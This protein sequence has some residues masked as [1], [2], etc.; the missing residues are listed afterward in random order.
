LVSSFSP[1]LPLDSRRIA[2]LHGSAT[3]GPHIQTGVV[4]IF[5][6]RNTMEPITFTFTTP[7]P[8]V[9]SLL[10]RSWNAPLSPLRPSDPF[11]TPFARPSPPRL[12]PSH[13]SARSAYLPPSPSFIPPSSPSLFS[14]HLSDQFGRQIDGV[15]HNALQSWNEL[16]GAVADAG[17]DRDWRVLWGKM[18]GVMEPYV[19]RMAH[20]LGSALNI[21]LRQEQTRRVR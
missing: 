8:R 16:K 10:F 7:L 6:K 5:D 18:S 20:H 15:R 17:V 3:L 12:H 2:W 9:G 1:L 19:E 14:P 21:V 11:E 4:P 13:V